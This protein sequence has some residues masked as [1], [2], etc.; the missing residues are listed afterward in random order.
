LAVG[1]L[2]PP[3]PPPVVPLPLVAVSVML[4]PD[5]VALVVVADAGP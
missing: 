1:R 2:V 4:P 3:P 5:A